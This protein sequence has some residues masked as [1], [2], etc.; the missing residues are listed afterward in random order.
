MAT[1]AGSRVRSRPVIVSGEVSGEVFVDLSGDVAFQDADDL[2][3]AE[4]F[5]AAA[6]DVAAGAWI[7]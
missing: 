3:G 1:R 6:G 2:F 4:A 7:R 5:L